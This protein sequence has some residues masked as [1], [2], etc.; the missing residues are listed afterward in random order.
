[1]RSAPTLTLATLASALASE[2][3]VSAVQRLVSGLT[4]TLLLATPSR[5]GWV[6]HGPE[7]GTVTALAVDSASPST[8][9]AGTF[10]GG[11]FKTTKGGGGRAGGEHGPA[12]ERCVQT[13][14]RCDDEPEQGLRVDGP[15]GVQDDRWGRELESRQHRPAHGRRYG[16]DRGRRSAG[17]RPDEP[18]HA[19]RGDGQ[20]RGVQDEGRGRE[21]E[22]GAHRPAPRRPCVPA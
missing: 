4:L 14:G 19:L 12:R 22:R 17:C 9:Y 3:K 2:R 21:L 8:A 5:A 6:S 1:M 16:A 18:E 11:G 10:G 7:G 20:R 15:R 13:G